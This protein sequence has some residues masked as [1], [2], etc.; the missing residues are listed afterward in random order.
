MNT[1]NNK[2]NINYTELL[3]LL[4]SKVNIYKFLKK[5]TNLSNEKIV[6]ISFD[7]QAKSYFSIYKND[8]IIEKVML[9][10]I[11]I[12]KKNFSNSKSI[13]DCGC[14]ELIKSFFLFKRLNFIKN[15]FANDISLNRL[16][17]G[18]KFIKKIRF[19]K[20]INL[21]CSSMKNLPLKNNSID[22]IFTSHS[23]EPNKSADA[24]VMIKELF[25][26]CN[27]GLCLHESHFQ[28]ANEIQKKRMQKFNY[29][30]NIEKILK[31]LDCTYQIIKLDHHHNK[32]NKACLF[33]VK[34][35]KTLKNKNN[36]KTYVDLDTKDQLYNFKNFLYSK[37][38]K[39]LYPVF[40][41]IPIFSNIDL[42]LPFQNT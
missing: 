20:K 37:K 30:R 9:P 22:V 19:N 28:S 21:F 42:Y 7:I 2:N 39:K 40:D 36:L 35:N 31:K 14:G 27:H 8:K 4:N 6:Q 17:L 13:M 16:Y 29:A 23:I 24:E 32:L 34:K 10:I 11:E 25:R 5:T 18:K 33:L 1:N 38:S 15:F 12:L 26:V 41:N 3:K